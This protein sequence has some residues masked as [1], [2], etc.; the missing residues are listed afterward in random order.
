MA[1]Y[2]DLVK[3]RESRGPAAAKLDQDAIQALRR[4]ISIEQAHRAGDSDPQVYFLLS[5]AYLESGDADRALAPAR[6]ACRL[7]P[8]NLQIYRQLSDVFITQDRRTEAEAAR[9]MEDAT[10]A[11]DQGKWQQAADLTE[12]LVNLQPIPYPA[13][14]YFNAIANLQLGNVDLAEDRARQAVRSE[15]ARNPRAE[16]VLASNSANRRNGSRRF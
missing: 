9:R 13:A 1:A 11:I 10:A 3:S 4:A 2:Y 12:P 14:L 15:G 8:L 5:V 7:D 16:Y 6:Q